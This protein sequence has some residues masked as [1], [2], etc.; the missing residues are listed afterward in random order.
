MTADSVLSPPKS[1]MTSEKV[2]SLQ[3]KTADPKGSIEFLPYLS[4][5]KILVFYSRS[6]V[7]VFLFPTA[8]MK[9]LFCENMD[10][11]WIE[12]EFETHFIWAIILSDRQST[13]K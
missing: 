4:F 13:K 9:N 8:P 7:L 5:E 2:M 12:T 3:L 1:E 10:T 6:L 11:K